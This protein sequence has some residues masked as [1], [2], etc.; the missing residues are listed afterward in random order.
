MPT[1][2]GFT[3]IELVAVIVLLGIIAAVAYPRFTGVGAYAGSAATAQA[4][5]GIRFAQEQALSRGLHARFR[6]QG[7]HYA[8]E[9]DTG[10]GFSAVPGRSRWTLPGNAR[11][12]A[13][14]TVTFD[15]LGR[16]DAGDCG[17]GNPIP[18]DPG[19]DLQVECETGFAHVP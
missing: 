3:L 10:P 1:Q 19:E 2:D 12:A 17:G 4:L 6:Y 5:S 14:G 18:L 8:V 11:F 16:P 9:Y 7:R 15:G 13:N